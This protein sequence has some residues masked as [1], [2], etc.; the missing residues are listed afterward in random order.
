[1]NLRKPLF[2]VIRQYITK[3]ALFIVYGNNVRSQQYKFGY[4]IAVLRVR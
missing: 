4:K 2:E 3:S 1:M